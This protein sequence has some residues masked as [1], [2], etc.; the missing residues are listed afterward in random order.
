M[1]FSKLFKKAKW[2]HKDSNIRISAVNE[3]LS[4]ANPEQKE[5][6]IS[7]LNNDVSELV[8]RA[9]LLKVNDFQVW[10]NASEKNTNK[11][12]TEYANTQVEKILL[13]QHTV[14][15][16]TEEK[17][18]FLA[19]HDKNKFLDAKFCIFKYIN[20]ISLFSLQYTQM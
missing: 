13:G 20:G 15:L 5:I 3:E 9:V 17:I 8:R 7:L 11:K 6:L 19:S 10:L 2:Q 4:L 14:T 1:I 16:S 12:I 18:D